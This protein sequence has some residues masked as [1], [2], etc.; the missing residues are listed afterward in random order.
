MTRVENF[1]VTVH[2]PSPDVKV[3]RERFNKIYTAAQL[4]GWE[5]EDVDIDENL[6]SFNLIDRLGGRSGWTAERVND[7]LRSWLPSAEIPPSA[8]VMVSWEY[9]VDGKWKK[10]GTLYENLT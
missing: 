6:I 5:V 9:S 4:D 8:D 3:Q 1:S 7:D 10:G 2:A